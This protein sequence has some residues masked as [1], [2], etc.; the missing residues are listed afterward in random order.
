MCR[1]NSCHADQISILGMGNVRNADE[2]SEHIK[3]C[4]QDRGMSMQEYYGWIV[5]QKVL[6]EALERAR[7]KIEGKTYVNAI[8]GECEVLEHMREDPEVVKA[9]FDRYQL[10]YWFT[11]KKINI[12]T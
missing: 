7:S 9:G 6:D 3:K 8:D 10:A 4:A 5:K 1:F 12:Y 2:Y 11:A